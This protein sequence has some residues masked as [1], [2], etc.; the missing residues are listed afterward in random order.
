MMGFDGAR[1][2][3]GIVGLGEFALTG[4]AALYPSYKDWALANCVALRIQDVMGKRAKSEERF[5][6]QRND[7]G[8]QDV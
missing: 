1:N 4:F 6:N 2:N 8:D 3:D 7:T 5:D